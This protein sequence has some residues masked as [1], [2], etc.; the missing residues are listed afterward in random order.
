MKNILLVLTL[1]C[2]VS[3]NTIPPKNNY[4][5]FPIEPE[6]VTYT[7]QPVIVAVEGPDGEEDF[8]VTGE[9]VKR[10]IQQKNYIDKV[11]KWRIVNNVP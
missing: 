1:G 7:R 10:A 8:I 4:S 9:L 2:L 3:C 5:V 11:K 6:W